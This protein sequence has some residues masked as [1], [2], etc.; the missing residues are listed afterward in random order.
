M[1]LE[2]LGSFIRQP[3]K[4]N[5][6]HRIYRAHLL[7]EKMVELLGAGVTVTLRGAN[8]HLWCDN[9]KLAVLARLKKTRL[10]AQ[11]HQTLGQ[12][13]LKLSIKVKTS[14]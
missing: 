2:S 1:T 5:S 14:R 12:A 9:E 13:E 4:E 11:C 6:F 8:V 3:D 7:Q 10:I